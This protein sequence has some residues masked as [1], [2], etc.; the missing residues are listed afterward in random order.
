MDWNAIGA[1]G[2]VLGALAVFV[3]L[4]YLSRQVKESNKL[5]K[6]SA[7]TDVM[8]GFG[9][10][11]AILTTPSLAAAMAKAKAIP[12]DFTPAEEVQV[13]QLCLRVMNVYMQGETAFKNG[14]L[15]ENSFTMLKRDIYPVLATY[16]GTAPFFEKALED[17]PSTT[18]WE[19]FRSVQ[20]ALDSASAK[21]P[22]R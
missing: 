1:I 4:I 11:N 2:E 16:P 6:S 9:E 18:D 22:R 5:A 20:T 14:H 3:T 17:Y 13:R 15:D 21:N 12:S 19:V 10:V 8:N 7:A